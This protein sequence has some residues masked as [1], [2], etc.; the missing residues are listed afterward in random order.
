M[1][2]EN[3]RFHIELFGRFSPILWDDEFG[4]D[5]K[6]FHFKVFNIQADMSWNK[7]NIKFW[8]EITIF[9]YTIYFRFFFYKKKTIKK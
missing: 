4:V 3:K 8:K 2:K 6:I 1:K 7:Y 5:D 9:N